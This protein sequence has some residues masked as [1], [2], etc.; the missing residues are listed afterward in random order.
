MKMAFVAPPFGAKTGAEALPIAPP[1]LAY[2]GA[3]THKIDPHIDIE[4]F[5]TNRDR[6]SPEGIDSDVVCISVLTP[7]APWAYAFADRVRARGIPVVMGG[8]HASVLPEEAKAHADSVVIGEAEGIWAE[9][10][11]DAKNKTLKPFYRGYAGELIDVPRPE[12][13]LLRS[14]YRFGSFFTQRGCPHN[15]AFCSIKAFYGPGVR[16]RPI[17]A[18][19]DE[20]LQSPY[21]MFINTDDNAWGGDIDRA[22]ELFREMSISCKDKY[23]F[24]SAD[25]ISVQTDKGDELLKWARAANM[26]SVMVG[27]ESS[28]KEALEEYNASIK[29]GSRGLDAIKKIKDHG[30][31][32]IAY[33]ILGSRNDT[34][35]DF[36]RTLDLC[37]RLG[38]AAHPVLL[39]PLP[40]TRLF[41]KYKKYLYKDLDWSFYDGMYAVF[42]HEDPVMTQKFRE[43]KLIHLRSDVFAWKRIFK[44]LVSLPRAGF[45]FAHIA[46]F[47]YQCQMKKGFQKLERFYRD[48]KEHE[49]RGPLPPASA[50]NDTSQ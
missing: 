27:W 24:G 1:V 8:W 21:N 42:E 44:R 39:H 13:S 31:D 10:L 32:V 4:L 28:N 22:I 3:L 15:C 2:L 12:T 6:I 46:S 37:D 49:P 29:Q 5:D 36:D 20:I 16:T 14:R 7:L 11:A 30:I 43:Q 33:V 17:P 25:L 23:W 40:G 47:F 18:V 35:D 19:I 45:P 9:F 26:M 41:D 50:D 48:K 38:I 34:P